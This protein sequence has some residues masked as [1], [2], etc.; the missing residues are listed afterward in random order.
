MSNTI[1]FKYIW[2]YRDF[3]QPC[4]PSATF[5][6]LL[7]EKQNRL[8]SIIQDVLY[9]RSTMLEQR[10][11]ER[12]FIGSKNFDAQVKCSYDLLKGYYQTNNFRLTRKYSVVL[13]I[14]LT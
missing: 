2:N 7:F 4:S 11:Y 5:W 14:L 3:E 12:S 10:D 8:L 6:P 1:C 9:L 13:L